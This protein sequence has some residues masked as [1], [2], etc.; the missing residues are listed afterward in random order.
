MIREDRAQRSLLDGELVWA[1]RHWVLFLPEGRPSGA[2]GPARAQD[3]FVSGLT[4]CV[5]NATVVRRRHPGGPWGRARRI[6][7][8]AF[9]GW[10]PSRPGVRPQ[11]SPVTP[12]TC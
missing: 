9:L 8:A 12:G 1:V 6:R 2:A 4:I 3:F 5:V 10:F 11:S 7:D